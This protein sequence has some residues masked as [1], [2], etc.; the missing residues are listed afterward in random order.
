MIGK[1]LLSSLL[2]RQRLRYRRFCILPALLRRRS[3]RV[4][5][6]LGLLG[7]SLVAFAAAAAFS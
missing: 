2:V 1:R 7:A 6:L 4:L 3:L 5:D